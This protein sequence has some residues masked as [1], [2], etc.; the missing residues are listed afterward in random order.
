M[1]L[2]ALTSAGLLTVLFFPNALHAQDKSNAE[3]EVLRVNLETI[4]TKPFDYL[5]AGKP[6]DFYGDKETDVQ[7]SPTT[8]RFTYSATKPINGYRQLSV[9]LTN[10]QSEAVKR[11]GRLF[12][13]LVDVSGFEFKAE[14]LGNYVEYKGLDPKPIFSWVSTGGTPTR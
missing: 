7:V 4:N 14:A 6:I 3:K 11:N 2:F 1:K 13:R 8:R 9:T 10:E 5:K 12:I